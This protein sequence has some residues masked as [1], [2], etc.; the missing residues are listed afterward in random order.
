MRN[1]LSVGNAAQTINLNNDGLSLILGMNND[2]NGGT[3]RNGSG[4]SSILQA[5]CFCIYGWPLTK[6]KIDNLINNINQKSML[7]TLDFERDDV[8]YR[9]ER[10][11]KPNILQFYVNDKSCGDLAM[12]ENKETQHEIDKVIGMSYTMFQ[13]IVAL[14][15][16]TDP[17][18]KMGAADQREIIEELLGITQISIRA[19]NLKK[20]I[21]LTKELVRSEEAMV[22]ATT[23]ANDRI[24]LSIT[25]SQADKSIWDR[26]NRQNIDKLV[27][28]LAVM[29]SID[30][31]NELPKFE[32][33]AHWKKFHQVFNND[34]DHFS[35]EILT[36]ER[37]YNKVLEQ[38][39]RNK[40]ELDKLNDGKD[41]D[42]LNRDLNRQQNNKTDLLKTVVDLENK[43]SEKDSELTDP[44]HLE[45]FTCGQELS[46][47]DHLV[48]VVSRLNSK[49]DELHEKLALTCQAI[50]NINQDIEDTKTDIENRKSS[51]EREKDSF[52]S[53][54]RNICNQIH[55]LENWLQSAKSSLNLNEKKISDLGDAPK[56]IFSTVDDL[57]NAKHAKDVL[58]S[59]LVR[60]QEAINP[61]LVQIDMLT[62]T[63]QEVNMDKLND[64]HDLFKHQEYL[65]KLLTNKDSFIRKKII[66]QNLPYLNTRLN[67][68]LNKLGLP[69]E[70]CIESDLSVDIN[71]LG[72]DYDFSQLSRGEMNRVIM[73]VSWAFRD[74]WENLNHRVNLFFVDEIL[75]NGTDGTGAEAG[76]QILKEFG[77]NRRNVFLISHRDELVGRIDRVLTVTKTN[78][79]TTISTE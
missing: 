47:T 59:D 32:Q 9:I 23:T 69:H 19:K 74:V 70:V 33:L 15:T 41:I 26:T 64:L 11:R 55:D 10:G 54:D 13:H 6:I 48:H 57:Y 5:L 60:A 78:G 79:F 34:R 76:L 4:K 72:C 30:F 43:I 29:D 2:S 61:Y 21:D 77:R 38:Y 12:G 50:D 63:L 56:T 7:V 66:E 17:F 25:S 40:I 36:L 1:F 24:S 67:M 31:D 3:T 65:F 75:D 58:M 44:G 68:Y 37:E 27:D 52:I 42:R 16:S 18:L 39:R 20:Q 53:E 46:G 35:R 71:L 73:A 22:K 51:I 8:R 45:C 28:E 14:N 49:R 62:A